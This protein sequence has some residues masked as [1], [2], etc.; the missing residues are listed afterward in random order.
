M[1]EKQ[2]PLFDDLLLRKESDDFSPLVK[3]DG[4]TDSERWRRNRRK[5]EKENKQNPIVKNSQDKAI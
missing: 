2:P 5:R 1:T 3:A 4:S